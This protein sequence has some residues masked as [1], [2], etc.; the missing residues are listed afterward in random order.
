MPPPGT[1]LH[2]VPRYRLTV[3]AM[4]WVPETCALPAA[5]RPARLAEF[6]ELLATALR[7]PQRP[8]PT[9]LRWWLDPAAEPAARDLAA[10]ESA[11]CTFF[12]FTFRRDGDALRL[13]VEV[14]AAHAGVLDALAAGRGT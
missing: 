14:P 2:P 1:G 3:E 5:D 9:V 8:S 6:D 10:R 13:D 4:T 7:G 11:C 12:S